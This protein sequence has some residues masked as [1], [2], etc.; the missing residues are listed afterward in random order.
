MRI[1]FLLPFFL[2]SIAPIQ[3]TPRPDEGSPMVVLSSKWFRNR[4]TIE[5]LDEPSAAPAAAMTTA[6]KNFERNRRNNDPAGVRDPNAD[7]V[8]GR[9]AAI[10]KMVQESRAPK[11]K[12]VDGFA[13]RA[14]V[15]NTS[16]KVV[17]IVFWEYQFKEAANPT[18]VARRQFLCGV[19]IKPDKEKELQAFSLSGPSDII[20]VSSL[21][22]KSGNVFEEKVVINRIEYADGTIWQRKDWNFAEVKLTFAR[23]V[24]TP[25]GSE[26]CRNL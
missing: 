21:A 8:D 15:Q 11:P 12:P 13:Y 5:K 23:A 17:E 9:S 2:L 6:N 7:T 26:M 14:K 3:N 16:T 22:N 18:S 25:W 10:D 24:G 19:N 4:Q 1:L 20:S